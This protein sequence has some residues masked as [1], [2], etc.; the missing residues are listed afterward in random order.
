M[1]V[2]KVHQYDGD[3]PVETRGFQCDENLAI[4]NIG[5]QHETNSTA[6]HNGFR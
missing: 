6:E 2:E 4:R 1:R 3:C 5:I